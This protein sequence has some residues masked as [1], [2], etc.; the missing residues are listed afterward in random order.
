MENSLNYKSHPKFKDLTKEMYKPIPN[1]KKVE[2]V[3]LEVPPI[4]ISEAILDD[5]GFTYTLDYFLRYVSE[6]TVKKIFRN[7]LFQQEALV[8]LFSVQINS[9]H[10]AHIL[11]QPVPELLSSYWT[12]LSKQ[13][14]AILFKYLLLQSADTDSLSSMISK[15]D[16]F[17]LKLMT[18]TG[19]VPGEKMLDFFKKM[20]T[21]IQKLAA[22]DMN[23]YDY[24]YNLAQDLSDQEFLEYLE[25]YS[26]IFVKLRVASG[27]I[28][29][30]ELKIKQSHSVPSYL[31]F[32]DLVTGI[33]QD[34]LHVVLVAFVEKKWLSQ[35]EVNSL[36]DHFNKV[37]RS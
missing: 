1:F 15:V 5:I 19:S 32:M 12:Y 6:S 35:N 36:E 7:S 30:I 8:E 11:N 34:S 27:Y 20:G 23:F 22:K 18:K 31:E 37:N 21:D 28:E 10:K 16:I 14:T 17:L 4:L 2:E 25:K 26:S 9:F 33:P 24:A 29:S 3:L 13:E